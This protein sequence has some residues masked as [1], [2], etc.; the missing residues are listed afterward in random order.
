[1]KSQKEKQTRKSTRKIRLSMSDASDIR[2]LKA[3][4]RKL[5]REYDEGELLMW[6]NCMP[7]SAMEEYVNG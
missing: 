2:L 3:F 4:A 6:C 5:C 7:L 1:M